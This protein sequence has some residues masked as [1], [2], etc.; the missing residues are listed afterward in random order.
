MGNWFYGCDF[1]SKRTGSFARIRDN[2]AR[3]GD[4]LLLSEKILH[5]VSETGSQ[6]HGEEETGV[7]I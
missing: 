1:H 6:H 2:L 7:T 3:F 4:F 5:E